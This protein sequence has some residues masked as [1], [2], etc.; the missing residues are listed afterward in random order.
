MNCEWPIDSQCQYFSRN[1]PFRS[2][3]ASLPLLNKFQYFIPFPVSREAHTKGN[4]PCRRLFSSDHL[5]SEG[6]KSKIRKLII[7]RVANEWWGAIEPLALTWCIS[8][9]DHYGERLH[10][11]GR[12]FYYCFIRLDV[13]APL[14]SPAIK[15]NKLACDMFFECKRK[16]N[17]EGETKAERGGRLGPPPRNKMKRKMRHL[18]LSRAPN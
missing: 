17:M 1:Y 5:E 9:S 14:T 18:W 10:E 12:Q 16:A 7:I 13:S 8:W 3:P 2:E 15:C 6:K 11:K 4:I